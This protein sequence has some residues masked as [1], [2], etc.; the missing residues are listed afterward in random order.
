MKKYFLSIVALAG[1]LF[2]T[3][4]QESLVEPQVDGPTTFTVQVPDAM[5]TKAIGDKENV[6]Q[7]L[8]AVY[9]NVKTDVQPLVYKTVKVEEG[10]GRFDVSFDLIKGQTY[11]LIFWAQTENAY[12]ASG[13]PYDLRSIDMNR[14]FPNNEKG[15]AF[16]HFEN[17]FKVDGVNATITLRRP[18]AQLNLRTTAAG[19][20]TDANTQP[21]TLYTSKISV[22]NVATKFNTVSGM[23]EDA[24]IIEFDAA[25]VPQEDVT[26]DNVLYK[27][28]SMNYLPVVGDDRALVDV[29]AEIVLAEGPVIK[30]SFTNIPL[31]E[32]YRTNIMGNLIS[33][34]TDFEVIINDKWS[35]DNDITNLPYFTVGEGR[36]DSFI[37][38]YNV[39]QDGD[40]IKINGGIPEIN[41]TADIPYVTI[42]KNIT[43][44][45]NG[46]GLNAS[47]PDVTV[48]TMIF[49][50][51]KGAQFTIIGEGNVHL[52]TAKCVNKLA[53]LISNEGG[54]VNIE[55]GNYTITALEY[56]D[57]LIPTFI[58]NNSTLGESVLNIKGGTFTYHRN[59]FRN[60]ANNKSA[61][62]I[63]NISGGEFNGL[64]YDEGAI[65]NQRASSTVPGD[66]GVIN[67]T[68]GVFNNVVIDDEFS[69]VVYA[70]TQAE[71]ESALIN[72][73]T[74]T[75]MLGAGNYVADIYNGTPARKSLTI[76]GSEG[77][78][79]GHTAT[80]GGQLR[81][82]LFDSFT[83]KNCE[84]IQRS[85]VKTWGHIV[86]GSGKANGVYTISNCTFNGVATQGIYINENNSSATYNIENCTFNGNF[87]IGHDGAITIQTN[88]DVECIVNVKGCEFKNIPDDCRRIYLA[89]ST[90][91]LFYDLT[92][93]T[94]LK[95]TT[96]Y[97]IETFIKLGFETINLADGNHV[98]PMGDK[99]NLQGKKLTL[100]GSKDAII[101]ARGVD[102]RDQFVTGATL[103][104][105]G[106]TLN[107]GTVNYMGFANTAS[108]TYTDCDING[109]Q[110]LFGNKV[111]F[112]RCNFDSNGA[113]HSV[114][115]YGAKEVNF[116]D[117]D[118]T[119][120]DRCIN[121]YSDNDVEGGKQVVNF[122][123]C[124]FATAN[125]ASEGAVEINSYFFSV[126]IEVNLTSCTAPAYGEMAYVSPWDS[127]NGS[128]TTINIE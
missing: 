79:F 108:L 51:L 82:D 52:N 26:V 110:F 38:A 99:V 72:E 105:E 104:F 3:S 25:N 126:G 83:I 64:P 88:K 11:D 8:V 34:T 109:L 40:V 10:T 128:K 66:A 74:H 85:G 100:V 21:M 101:D 18:F 107:F 53:A 96:A 89:P 117:C 42:D 15:A 116:T 36:Y 86:F 103:A 55:S 95:A 43:L 123:N 61:Q 91:G 2:A 90:E 1:M 12:V 111:S 49:R 80:T 16:F 94:D 13:A 73:N 48:N 122:T 98:M 47:I 20:V 121:C 67:V 127:T 57:A 45:L 120:G 118:F 69:G 113:E 54:I 81:L 71:M 68:G 106:L 37:D 63:M 77:T 14:N 39:A 119:Y 29:T 56:P 65:W 84:I 9:T 28:V 97:E 4:C 46:Y 114:W 41:A 22:T 60:F 59:L 112:E 58:D 92:L 6:N 70:N 27:Y 23:G 75:I 78:K 17:N 87:G 30:H 50:V 5:G 124:E 76:I 115:T 93:N 24:D 102:A 33:G 125:T 32:N 31:Q 44:D 19:L 7:L 62:A 35:G